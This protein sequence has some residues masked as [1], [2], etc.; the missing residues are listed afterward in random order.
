MPGNKKTLDKKNNAL[1]L[2]NMIELLSDL[3]TLCRENGWH[4]SGLHTFVAAE[5]L[6]HMREESQ[7]TQ[8]IYTIIRKVA[9][10]D[11]P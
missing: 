2:D 9:H 1:L 5:E 10:N 4:R 3:S 11:C 6:R 7:H 8:D